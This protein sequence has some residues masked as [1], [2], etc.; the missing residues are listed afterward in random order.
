[1]VPGEG[2]FYVYFVK[3]HFYREKNQSV[4][5]IHKKRIEGI[6]NLFCITFNFTAIF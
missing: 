6:S 3:V 5:Y 1:M 2:R 4:S